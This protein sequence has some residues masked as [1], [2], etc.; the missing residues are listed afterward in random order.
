M[1]MIGNLR[2]NICDA[3]YLPAVILQIFINNLTGQWTQVTCSRCNNN[4]TLANQLL[5]VS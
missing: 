4:I 3:T 2:Q 1:N 5:A